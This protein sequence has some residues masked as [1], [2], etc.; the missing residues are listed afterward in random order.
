MGGITDLT[1]GQVNRNDG[2]AIH[3]HVLRGITKQQSTRYGLGTA[4]DG[5]GSGGQEYTFPEGTVPAGTDIFVCYNITWMKLY[6]GPCASNFCLFLPDDRSNMAWNGD[7]ALE[8]FLDGIVIETFGQ[9]NV[10]G[11]GQY[12]DYRGSWAYKDISGEWSYGLT[13]CPGGSC[14]YPHLS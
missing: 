8:L 11:T 5:R 12:W 1:N 13:Y 9:T 4:N 3:I 10:D 2:R 6:L 14:S 7:D